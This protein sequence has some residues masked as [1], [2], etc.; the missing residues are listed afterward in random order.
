MLQRDRITPTDVYCDNQG[1]VK[2]TSIPESTLNKKHN[3]INYHVVREAA[4]AEIICVVK[5]DN[6]TNLA[7]PLT[8]LMPYL[9]KKELL[10]QIFYYY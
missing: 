5:E 4:A 6:V 9:Q 10:V 1:V 3:S 8:N 2:N 7:D